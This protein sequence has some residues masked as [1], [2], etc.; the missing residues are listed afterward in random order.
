M[1]KSVTQGNERLGAHRVVGDVLH[2]VDV[3][4][5]HAILVPGFLPPDLDE[6]LAEAGVGIRSGRLP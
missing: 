3:E 1:H 4:E 2:L 6:Q 5:D